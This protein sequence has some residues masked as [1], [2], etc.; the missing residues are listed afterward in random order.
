M[1]ILFG[2]TGRRWDRDRVLQKL[3]TPAWIR[4]SGEEAPPTVTKVE[5]GCYW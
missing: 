5:Q 4:P 1:Q 3:Q 2:V